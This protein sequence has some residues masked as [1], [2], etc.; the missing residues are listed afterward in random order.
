MNTKRLES[1]KSMLEKDSSDS[2]LHY[3]I[4]KEHESLS[5]YDDA[6]QHFLSGFRQGICAAK[7]FCQI[8]FRRKVACLAKVC[9]FITICV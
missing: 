3:A 6:L 1:L 9:Q 4:A 7:A 5:Q 8:R 2:F